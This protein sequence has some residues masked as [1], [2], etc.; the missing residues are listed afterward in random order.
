M[1]D[2][3]CNNRGPGKNSKADK[4]ERGKSESGAML[5]QDLNQTQRNRSR[6]EIGRRR[7]WQPGALEP[8]SPSSVITN[9]SKLCAFRYLAVAVVDWT[10][11][12]GFVLNLQRLWLCSAL[13]FQIHVDWLL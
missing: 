7:T 12:G 1:P 8:T 11:D 5:A 6:K 4:V 10:D 9:A 3:R 2:A 13:G